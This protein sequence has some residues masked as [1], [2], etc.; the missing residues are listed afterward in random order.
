MPNNTIRIAGI[1]NN[2]I[3][4][5][6]GLRYVIFVQGCKHNCP[7][8]HNPQT[9]DPDGGY[10]YPIDDI[11]EYLTSDHLLSGITL[12]GGEPFL[13]AEKCV[14]IARY[15]K[16][17]GLNVWVYSGFTYENILKDANK[18]ALLQY[19]DVLV[20]GRFVLEEKDESLVFKGSRNQRIIDVQK[21]LESGTVVL[22][23]I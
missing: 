15:A 12:S 21:S 17:I 5:G 10:D 23:D 9:H 18:I 14:E 2:S 11:K 6:S 4:D 1:V 19:C 22:W 20:D 13:Q 7:G 3:V 8:C 16:E